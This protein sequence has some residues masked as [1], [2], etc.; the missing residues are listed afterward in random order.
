MS[1]IQQLKRQVL[2]ACKKNKHQ[3][4]DWVPNGTAAYCT[5]T[6]CGLS[7]CAES[8]PD[9]P[10]H[11]ETS[12]EALAAKCGTVFGTLRLPNMERRALWAGLRN[13]KVMGENKDVITFFLNKPSYFRDGLQGAKFVSLT[14]ELIHNNFAGEMTLRD[15]QECYPDC[16]IQMHIPPDGIPNEIE[17][18]KVFMASLVTVWAGS[19]LR[20]INTIPKLD[21]F[22]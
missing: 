6:V 13:T 14:D 10:H 15:F 18:N 4:G 20:I 1:N 11:P 12:G 16:K 5:C 17:A 21:F 22:L 19:R 3:M 8:A 7:A 9:F 2:A